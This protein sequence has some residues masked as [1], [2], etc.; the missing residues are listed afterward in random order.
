MSTCDKVSQKEANFAS[1]LKECEQ[2]AIKTLEFANKGLPN[3]YIFRQ[4][5]LKH[6]QVIPYP[7]KC[8]LGYNL[9]N[10]IRRCE[11]SA[12]SSSLNDQILLFSTTLYNVLML[13]CM[14][15]NEMIF[16]VSSVF[17]WRETIWKSFPGTFSLPFLF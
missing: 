2:R 15:N 17:I 7:N 3:L 4:F 13:K 11:I 14:I 8:Y 1:I 6:V 16:F 10:E 9:Q 12:I 5:N